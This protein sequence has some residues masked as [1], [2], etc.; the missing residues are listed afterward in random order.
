MAGRPQV[1]AGVSLHCLLGSQQ[2]LRTAQEPPELPLHGWA[3]QPV[4]SCSEVR[5][6]T[7]RGCPLGVGGPTGERPQEK[8]QHSPP[9]SGTE[10]TGIRGSPA[11]GCALA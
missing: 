10:A 3:T 11:W 5:A 4:R 1:Y 7:G 2:S 8:Q 6:L 9:A